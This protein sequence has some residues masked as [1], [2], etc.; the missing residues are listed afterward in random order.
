MFQ[1]SKNFEPRC[2]AITSEHRSPKN[3][4]LASFIGA[5]MHCSTIANMVRNELS[6]TVNLM[7][8]SPILLSDKDLKSSRDN[9]SETSLPLP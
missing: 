9:G 7:A 4:D 3:E 6:A 2:G 5:I 8:L 1:L